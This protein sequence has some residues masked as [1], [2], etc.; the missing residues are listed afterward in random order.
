MG[1]GTGAS[2]RGHGRE[3]RGGS[4]RSGGPMRR[5]LRSATLVLAGA[6]ALAGCGI[7]TAPTTGAA[8][9]TITHAFGSQAVATRVQSSPPNGETV[10]ELLKRSYAIRT[11]PG[12][13]VVESIAGAA[14]NGSGRR[15]TFWVNG[16]APTLRVG[17]VPVHHGD[18][19]WW[20]LHDADASSSI[21]AV[22]GSYPE[23][24]TSG[25][26]GRK[27]PTVLECA[28][29]VQAACTVVASEL[30]HVGVK[31]ADQLLGGGSGSDSLAVIV[32]TFRDIRGVI[33]AELLKAGPSQSGVYAQFA[34]VR[35]SVLELDN[36]EGQV[37]QA[38]GGHA[39]LVAAT[40]Q[41][42]LGEPAWLIVGTDPTGVVAAARL[43]KPAALR[44]HFAVAVAGG[45]DLPLPLQPTA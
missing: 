35:D 20:D 11:G 29:D 15:W 16:I 10:K 38:V 14:A 12:G 39:G 40:E 34:G 23:P 3:L 28:P 5:Q 1:A 19:V 42:G 2:W 30:R 8:K 18:Q 21:P 25:T 43:L 44:D 7:Q 37:V 26:G 33:A 22:V 4:L 13:R 27:L 24:F 17:R 45:H 36:P 41:P 32:G 9:L 31:V 6:V